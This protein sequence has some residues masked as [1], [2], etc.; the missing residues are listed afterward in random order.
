[1]TDYLKRIQESNELARQYLDE[2][3]VEPLEYAKFK[4]K[5]RGY[6]LAKL[7]LAETTEEPDL[8]RLAVLSI[9]KNNSEGNLTDNAVLDERLQKYDC[10]R[11]NSAVNKRVLLI[12]RVERQLG[13]RLDNDEAAAMSTI[14]D[15]T[16]HVY[17]KY[18][19]LKERT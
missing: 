4:R 11:T 9:K 5:L 14:D 19:E 12:M 8:Y 7:M 2:I 16:E 15:L 17:C 3:I 6:L 18:R 10:H 1:M 13:I